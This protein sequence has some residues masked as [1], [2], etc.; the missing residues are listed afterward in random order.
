MRS[1]Y[2]KGQNKS[3]SGANKKK[4]FSACFYPAFGSFFDVSELKKR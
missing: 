4:F 1:Q 3:K 2:K